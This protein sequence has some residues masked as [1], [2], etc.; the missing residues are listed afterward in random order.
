MAKETSAPARRAPLSSQMGWFEYLK[1][2]PEQIPKVIPELES[3][4]AAG[5]LATADRVAAGS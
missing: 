5:H 3:V 4:E 2:S 1:S